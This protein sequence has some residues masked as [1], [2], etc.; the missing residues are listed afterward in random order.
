MTGVYTD[1][2][3]AGQEKNRTLAVRQST[4]L[5]PLNTAA[6][7][8]RNQ[9][10]INLTFFREGD[11][12]DGVD[13]P[14]NFDLVASVAS[15]RSVARN[16]EP[17]NGRVE[18]D[19]LIH[20]VTDLENVARLHVVLPNLFELHHVEEMLDGRSSILAAWRQLE[21]P[22]LPNSGYDLRLSVN[23]TQS[24]PSRPARPPRLM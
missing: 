21:R 5:V 7:F 18:V 17:N 16:P 14:E 10:K 15:S 23:E 13:G 20:L 1:E 6:G 11:F 22:R 3:S 19:A 24:R 9:L 12:V 8:D 4:A 2:K